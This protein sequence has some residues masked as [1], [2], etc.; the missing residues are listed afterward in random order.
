MTPL[1]VRRV[2]L[3]CICVSLICIQVST[4]LIRVSFIC[5]RDAVHGF[6]GSPR[7]VRMK[8][9]ILV[10]DMS[11]LYMWLD[12]S[13]CVKWHIHTCM[14][15]STRLRGVAT[16]CEGAIWHDFFHS[17]RHVR[18]MVRVLQRQCVAVCCSV[19]K[20]GCPL[21]WCLP[22]AT[23]YTADGKCVAV[24][25]CVAVC[26]SVLQCD[27]VCWS[28]DVHWLDVFHSWWQVRQKEMCVAVLRCVAV[29]CS[30]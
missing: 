19:L 13:I 14:W 21:A 15:L 20:C 8:W 27:A 9:F 23:E 7:S 11:H 29:C 12:W 10:C 25:R 22:F 2:L 3:I 6:I 30:V 5:I 28:V 26:C 4:I 17:R 16:R 24:L 18:Q 1:Y